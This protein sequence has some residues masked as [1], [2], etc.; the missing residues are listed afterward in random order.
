MNTAIS[1]STPSR[2]AAGVTAAYLRDLSRRAAHSPG[3]RRREA[4]RGH[5]VA[6]AGFGRDRD[7]CARRRAARD[8]L[9]A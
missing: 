6:A 7:D 3:D 5:R 4:I 1:I 9:T 2:I 8:A